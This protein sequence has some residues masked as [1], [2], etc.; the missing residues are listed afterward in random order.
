MFWKVNLHSLLD[1]EGSISGWKTFVSIH[2]ITRSRKIAMLDSNILHFSCIILL[3]ITN[4]KKVHLLGT[5]LTSL[6]HIT[7]LSKPNMSDKI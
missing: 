1:D 2:E 6:S 7:F 3:F 4:Q 5:K